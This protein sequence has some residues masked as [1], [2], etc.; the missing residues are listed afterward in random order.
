MCSSD[1][2][3]GTPGI[4]EEDYSRWLLQNF[5]PSEL[6]DPSRIAVTA[7]PDQDWLNHG[8]EFWLGTDPHVPSAPLPTPWATFSPDGT[9][10]LQ[11][12]VLA[13][14]PYRLEHTDS[15]GPGSM[16]KVLQDI[17]SPTPGQITVMDRTDPNLPHRFFRV[18]SPI[19]P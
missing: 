18:T 12:R 14:M 7:N 2:P 13:D 8:G 6:L 11:I 16:W 1:L 5:S 3:G 19:K 4:S 15:L 9:L 10:A 17:Q